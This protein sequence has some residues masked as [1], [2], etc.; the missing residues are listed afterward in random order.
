[1]P[2]FTP[3]H[4]APPSSVTHTLRLGCATPALQFSRSQQ[5]SCPSAGQA[6]RAQIRMVRATRR[7]GTSG[8]VWLTIQSGSPTRV[9]V[10]ARPSRIVIK[11]VGAGRLGHTRGLYWP[12]SATW[13]TPPICAAKRLA[14]PRDAESDL[15]FMT[16][17][18]KQVP[19]R[20]VVGALHAALSRG[21]AVADP[22]LEER[23]L[24]GTG[25]RTLKPW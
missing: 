9:G 15:D 21:R 22:Q 3:P 2:I 17:T 19:A 6:G 5:Q 20:H 10:S 18:S 8:V 25:S 1:M 24:S 16:T 14:T 12:P 23:S 13:V 7:R 4:R 11:R